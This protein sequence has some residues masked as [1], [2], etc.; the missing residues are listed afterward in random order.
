MSQNNK[1]YR[2]CFEILLLRVGLRSF[3]HH[4]R[5]IA[6]NDHG[7]MQRSHDFAVGDHL[8]GETE[9]A[10]SSFKALSNWEL[11]LLHRR[12]AG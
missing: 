2:L 8:E 9:A 3:I 1:S 4:F 12:C 11:S 5:L 7:H 6:A 10:L